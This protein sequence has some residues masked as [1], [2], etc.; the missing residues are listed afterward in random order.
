VYID[1][2]MIFYYDD[3]VLEILLQLVADDHWLPKISKN[4]RMKSYCIGDSVVDRG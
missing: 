1:A 3:I 4:N 2:K